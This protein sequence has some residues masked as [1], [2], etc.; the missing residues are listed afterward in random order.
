M[1]STVS[2]LLTAAL[3]IQILLAIR[4]SP[5]EKTILN[6]KISWPVETLC[7][8]RNKIG[9]GGSF[10]CHRYTIDSCCREIRKKLATKSVDD[11]TDR[12]Q[13]RICLHGS[14]SSIHVQE[15]IVDNRASILTFAF[16]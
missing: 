13:G 3:L 11:Y 8:I 16:L 12:I 5:K 4:T 15:I 10:F 6:R 9:K 1:V 14:R 2:V 7:H